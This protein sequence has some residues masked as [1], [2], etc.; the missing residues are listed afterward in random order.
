MAAPK[1]TKFQ[2]ERDRHEIA[3]LYLRGRRQAEIVHH[4]NESE[5]DYTLTQQMIS[6][7]LQAIQGRWRKSALMDMDE[8]KTQELAKI[9]TLE[10]TYWDAWERS[11]EDAETATQKQRGKVT[12][13]VGEDGQFV[14]EQPAEISKTRKGQAGDP[15]FLTGVQWCIERRCKILGIDAPAEVKHKGAGEKGEILFRYVDNLGPGV[16]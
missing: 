9:D 7:D 14:A 15:R 16:I 3:A 6:Y 10:L 8:R 5:R 13:G 11:C 4:L 12:K 1:R 2:I